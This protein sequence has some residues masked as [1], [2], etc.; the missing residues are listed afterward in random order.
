LSGEAARD[1]IFGNPKGIESFSPALARSG[2]AGIN[3]NF[4]STLKGL[5]QSATFITSL[6][7]LQP[8]QG[9]ILWMMA[10]PA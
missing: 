3:A 9:L 6:L 5:N 1:N 10:D 4:F 2:Y 7:R 8:F